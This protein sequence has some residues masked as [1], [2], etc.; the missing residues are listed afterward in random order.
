MIN[1]EYYLK[2]LIELQSDDYEPEESHGLADDV[3]VNIL[4]ELGFN[5]IVAEYNRIEKWYA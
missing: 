1:R 4:L 3:L 2:R 5:D